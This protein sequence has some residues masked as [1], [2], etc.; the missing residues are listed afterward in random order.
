MTGVKKIGE[1]FFIR[2][3]DRVLPR[4][5]Q[6]PVEI[7]ELMGEASADTD[8]ASGL[9]AQCE[10]WKPVYAA[11]VRRDKSATQAA[12]ETYLERFPDDAVAQL[13]LKEVLSNDTSA[14]YDPSGVRVY[15]TK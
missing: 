4:G 13:I 8:A 10:A 3:I 7:F 1:K 6:E 12:V 9:A 14:Q 15:E 11:Y 5:V 2:P